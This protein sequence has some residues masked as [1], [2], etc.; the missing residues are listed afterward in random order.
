MSSPTLAIPWTVAHQTPLS[1]VFPMQEYWNG[2]PF[3]S[4]RDLSHPGIEPTSPVSPVLTGRVFTTMPP[5][6]LFLH[7]GEVGVSL[8]LFPSSPPQKQG[9]LN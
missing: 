5:G 7:R 9:E 1:M 2:L 4:P 8:F 3:P 6:K